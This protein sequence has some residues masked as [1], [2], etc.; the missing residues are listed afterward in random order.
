MYSLRRRNDFNRILFDKI[1]DSFQFSL[2]E[3]GW[4]MDGIRW[5]TNSRLILVSFAHRVNSIC[6]KVKCDVEM[7]GKTTMSV[8]FEEYRLLFG[9]RA[10]VCARWTVYST[11]VRM[12]MRILH[13]QFRMMRINFWGYFWSNGVNVNWCERRCH[14]VFMDEILGKWNEIQSSSG[15][16]WYFYYVQSLNT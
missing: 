12:A 16:N 3:N 4:M 2:T 13:M 5:K 1:L 11:Y 15:K 8:A 6:T 7:S 10:C 14:S 9:A